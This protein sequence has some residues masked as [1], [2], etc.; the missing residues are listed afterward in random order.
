VT[1]DE[2]EK[3]ILPAFGDPRLYL[4]LGRGSV[5]GGRLRSEAYAS[6]RLDQQLSAM[7]SECLTRRHCMQIDHAARIIR[8]SPVFGWHEAEFA[9]AYGSGSRF[10]KR[11]AIDRAIFNFIE[12]HMLP[13]EVALLADSRSAVR[14][15]DYDWRLNDLSGGRSDVEH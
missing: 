9:K 1:L 14:Y 3:T 4:A 2:I 13:T 8:V 7:A 6:A 15:L 12:P 5:G 10:P 11:S